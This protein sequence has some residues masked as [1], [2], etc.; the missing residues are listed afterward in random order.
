MLASVRGAR[1]GEARVELEGAL[2]R[3]RAP[4]VV[5]GGVRDGARVV[6]QQ[7]VLGAEAQGLLGETRRPSRC[8]VRDRGPRQGVRRPDRLALLVGLLG[9]LSATVGSPWSASKIASSRSTTTPLASNSCVSNRARSKL[10]CAA[11]VSPAASCASPSAMT[12]SGS[13]RIAAALPEP[14]DRGIEIA[15][16][17]GESSQAHQRRA[18]SPARAAAPPRRTAVSLRAT[19]EIG[20]AGC[21]GGP[22]RT[23]GS[24]AAPPPALAARSNASSAPSRSPC[25][26]R[27]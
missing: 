24:P 10:C 3:V 19:A 5:A 27:A 11:A 4:L 7:R 13:G 22:G 18:R 9:E 2:S 25:S 14:L 23:R 21:P 26:S 17:H 15:L 16:A 6:Q 12:Y 1:R 20:Q 8:R